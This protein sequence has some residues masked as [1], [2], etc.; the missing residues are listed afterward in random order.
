M[1]APYFLKSIKKMDKQLSLHIIK[2]VKLFN[3]FI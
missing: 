3:E 1:S 2:E